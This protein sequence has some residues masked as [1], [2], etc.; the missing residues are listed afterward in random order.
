MTGVIGDDDPRSAAAMLLAPF[1]RQFDRR[2][3]G[4]AATVE[5]VGLVAASAGT[6]AFGEV[7]HAAVMQAETGV[8]QGLRLRR[9]GVDQ[10]L[11][12]VSKAIG[13]ATLREIQISPVIVVPQP[14]TLAADK[15]LF[16]SLDTGHQALTGKVVTPGLKASIRHQVIE[17]WRMTTQIEQIHP[18]KPRFGFF[19]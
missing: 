7:E 5:Q 18:F 3:T 17:T 4:F 1:A 15:D 2:L 13:A 16:R 19:A 8:D 10:C 9:D 6:Q 11:G 14:R 12:A